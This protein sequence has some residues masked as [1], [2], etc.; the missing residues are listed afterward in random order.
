MPQAITE[1][2]T[3]ADCVINYDKTIF[4]A[5]QK[6]SLD[7]KDAYFQDALKKV[8]ANTRVDFRYADANTIILY[9]LPDPVKPGKISGKILDEKGENLPGASIKV[10]ENRTGTQSAVDG[11]YTL[12][13][14][15]GIYTIEVSYMSFQTQRITGVVVK[16]GKNTLLEISLNP[17]TKGLKEVVV[18]AGYK[19]AST[20]GLLAK[21]KNASEISNGISAEQIARTPDKNIGESLKRISGLNT[22]DNKFVLVRGIGERYNSAMLDG[23]VLPSTEAQSR[24]FSFDL[25]P[26]N[27]VDNV[28]VSKTVT[29]DMNASFGGGLIQINTK[30]IPNENFMSFSAGA[31]YND[32]T[33]GK[34]FISHKRGKYDYLG[35]DDG[36]RDYPKDL[37]S[38]DGLTPEQITEQSKRFTKD[39]FTVYKNKAAPSQNYQFSIG[40]LISIDTTND[41]KLGFTGSL[42]YRNTQSNNIINEQTRGDW[43]QRSTNTGNAYGFNTTLGGLLNVGLQLGKNRFS[44]RNTYTHLYDNT[45]YRITGYSTANEDTTLPPTRI[46]ETDDPTY[47]DLLQNKL[48][49]QH[50]LGKVKIEWDAARTSVSRQEKD[51]II[52]ESIPER[53]GAEYLYYYVPANNSEPRIN[54][55]SRHH[56]QNKE[57]HYSWDLAATLPFTIGEIRSSV[58]VG[59]FG[60]QKKANFDWAIAA[61]TRSTSLPDSMR[62]IPIAEIVKP[63]NMGPERFQYSIPGNYRDSFDGK[64]QTHAGFIMFDNRLMEKLRLVWGVRGEYYKYTPGKNGNNNRIDVFSIKPDP[65]WQ[66]LPSANLTYSPLSSLNIRAAFSSS[67]V[68]P[69]LMDNSQ[70]WRFSPILGGQFGNQGLYST[71]INSLDFKTEWFPGLGEI[72]SVGGFYKKFDKPTETVLSPQGNTTAYYLKSADWAKVYGLEFE[73]RKNFGFL[74]DNAIFSNMTAYGNLTLQKSEVRSTYLISNP[75]PAGP[76]LDVTSKQ[77]RPMYGQTP[78]LVN[79]GLQYTGNHFGF[80]VMYNKSGFKT[81]LVGEAADL[82]EYERPREQVDAQ[83]SYRFLKNKFEIRINAGNLLNAASTFYRNTASYEPNPDFIPGTSDVSDAQRL[84]PGFTNKYEEGDRIMFSQKFGRTYS[85]TLTWN[86]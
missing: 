47:T 85:T 50:Q 1:L 60:N 20:A 66:W 26:S 24:N 5:G 27:M 13:V 3:K 18:T 21:Q 84:K 63:E 54:P 82:V 75:D 37:V 41:N 34:D 4:N 12:S 42:S 57:Q 86:F 11:S 45:L 78:Y 48:S 43:Y 51:L 56:Y 40:R 79:A 23:T 70:F 80:N 32:Q 14:N 9:K 19:K 31:S 44:F 67:V 17:D 72:L 73:L 46:Q 77:S 81:Y 76:P 30:D 61:L 15:P 53:I 8:L 58:K 68:R 2:Q 7:L 59:Y 25:I 33:T 35:F 49:G 71:R 6:I 55:L 16:E 52:A 28:V 38:T 29:P 74:S 69:E 36:T 65:R 10:I 83:I 64:S 62:Y 39:N 22:I